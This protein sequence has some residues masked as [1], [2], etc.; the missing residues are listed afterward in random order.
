M[1]IRAEL[2]GALAVAFFAIGCGSG[3]GVGGD[4]A[5]GD[6]EDVTADA[7]ADG[8][9]WII[10]WYEND[11]GVDGAP[12]D[13]R[14]D[15]DSGGW[16]PTDPTARPNAGL[17]EDPGSAG[18][19]KG[20]VKIPATTPFCVDRYEASI[21]VV[22]GTGKEVSWSPYY[23]P[24]KTMTYRAVSTKGAV[25]QAYM[26]GETSQIACENAGKRLCTNT[27][28]LR[29]CRGPSDFTYPYGN[30]REPGVCN[31]ARAVHPAIQC[32]GTSASWIW[33]ELG[34]AGIDQQADT[35]AKTG[36]HT[37]CVTA[38]GVYDMMGNVHEWIWDDPSKYSDP[39]KAIDFRGGF[40]ADTH[41]N[42]DGCL[43]Q[44]TAHN[45]QHWDYSTGFRCCAD[46]K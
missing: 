46:A 18:C 10:P 29:A 16:C 8:R 34:Y 32:F 2:A 28:W 19:P 22:D 12:G 14:F 17:A 3:E 1:P 41:L 25:P 35:V 37:G 9:G 31:D 15:G 39:V 4:V 44:T 45:F 33:S 36:S 13:A 21:V 11:G 5:D 38:E 20:M 26:S 24:P 7:Q 30:S 23:P 43:Y 42:G 40:Y 27:E 6:A